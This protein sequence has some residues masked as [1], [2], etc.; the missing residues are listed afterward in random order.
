MATKEQHVVNF[1]GASGENAVNL[2]SATD[3][4][5]YN[6]YMEKENGSPASNLHP[7]KIGRILA[8]K[9]IEN[10]LRIEKKGI[11]RIAVRFHTFADANK[12]ATTFLKNDL[13]LKVYIPRHLTSCQ[14]VV[15]DVD[16][17]ITIDD[18]LKDIK[19]S[20]KVL[21]A[22]R[23]NRRVKEGD[24]FKYEPTNT[25]VLTFQGS[26]LPKTVSL[27]YVVLH[28]KTYILPVVR[29]TKCLRFGHNAKACKGSERCSK[30]GMAPHSDSTCVTKC[31][32]CDEAHD[33]L[34][35]DCPELK[36]QQKIK[37]MMAFENITFF[38]AAKKFP[39]IK[40]PQHNN[41]ANNQPR[42]SPQLFPPLRRN[43]DQQP[44][45]DNS[46]PTHSQSPAQSYARAA[47][48]SP[49]RKRRNISPGYNQAEHN[50]LLW[51]P[52]GNSSPASS[53]SQSIPSASPPRYSLNNNN[54][55]NNIF[56]SFQL[57]QLKDLLKPLPNPEQTLSSIYNILAQIIANNVPNNG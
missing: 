56:N 40:Y 29:C 2:F 37:E 31:I 8:E 57:Q 24:S 11:N 14:G 5:P 38:E 21:S 10:V 46:S 1:T 25:V 15:R 41:M 52:N 16:T 42:S 18:I 3:L 53:G 28:V 50:E 19:C 13:Q 4:G 51:F 48:S 55:Q 32:H 44:A 9:K 26:V 7:M 47:S 34:Y 22:R 35:K 39:R 45:L 6:V 20:Y 36:R 12:L 23:L 49:L 27:Y 43:F 17:S 54:N 33:A 30:C